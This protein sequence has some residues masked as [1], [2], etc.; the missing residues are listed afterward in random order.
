MM[1]ASCFEHSY[2]FGWSSA[3]FRVAGEFCNNKDSAVFCFV[4]PCPPFPILCASRLTCMCAV[5]VLSPRS[6][7]PSFFLLLCVIFSNQRCYCHCFSSCPS[8]QLTK[9]TWRKNSRTL[10]RSWVKSR[11]A[12]V[13][14]LSR[15]WALRR[16]CRQHCRRKT[17]SSV[18][19][20]LRSRW[21]KGVVPSSKD[22]EIQ[23]REIYCHW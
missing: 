1:I 23:V 16:S 3:T 8:W 11:C 15:D 22:T 5:L 19:K 18:T 17:S 20:T 12:W 21:E 10:S 13:L 7:L 14:S 2:G 4:L 6:C 9:R